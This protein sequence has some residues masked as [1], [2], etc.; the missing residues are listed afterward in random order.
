MKIAVERKRLVAALDS[1][2]PALATSN[3]ALPV[4]HGVRIVVSCA[5]GT[6]TIEAN[7]LDLHLR[8][9]LDASDISGVYAGPVVINARQLRLIAARGMPPGD[10]TVTLDPERPSISGGRTTAWVDS[11]PA[12]QWPRDV[13]VTADRTVTLTADDVAAIKRVAVAASQ[14]WARP[15][16]CAVSVADGYAVGADSYRLLAA[17]ISVTPPRPLL[18]PL[19]VVKV[20]PVDGVDLAVGHD[21]VRWGDDVAGGT[22]V[23]RV[24]EYPNWQTIMPTGGSDPLVIE[25]APFLAAVLPAVAARPN[26]AEPLRLV[27]VGGGIRLA[28]EYAGREVFADELDLGGPATG[29]LAL[30]PRFLADLLRSCTTE[31]VRLT[32]RDPFKPVKITDDDDEPAMRALQ[33]PVRVDW[34]KSHKR[35]S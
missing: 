8:T 5:T 4:L 33:M 20:L 26:S 24:G 12:D 7:N 9:T 6:A 32:I 22:A 13:E 2:K 31:R 14:D 27:P 15:I 11:L 35:A 16:L 21:H 10:L 19:P 28:A 18:L 29:V 1:V 17:R 25:R 3:S 34:P 30:N 23:L